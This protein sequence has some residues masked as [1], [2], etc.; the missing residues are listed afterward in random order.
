MPPSIPI[1]RRWRRAGAALLVALAHA[2]SA[3]ASPEAYVRAMVR[4]TEAAIERPLREVERLAFVE[5]L[6]AFHA[7]HPERARASLVILPEA[8]EAMRAPAIAAVRPRMLDL[9]RGE[10][11]RE[12]ADGAWRRSP[13]ANILASYDPWLAVDAEGGHVLT[14]SD[15]AGLLRLAKLRRAPSALPPA[16]PADVVEEASGALIARFRAASPGER[17]VL[18]NLDVL[19][20]GIADL[21]PGADAATRRRLMAH[22]EQGT[23]LAEPL[24]QRL[25]GVTDVEMARARILDRINRLN[26]VLIEYQT[27]QNALDSVAG[28]LGRW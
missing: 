9:I 4:F 11:V 28:T 18:S 26:R 20:T 25:Y 12:G 5:E 19:W 13:F 6:E 8:T 23:A 16:P 21:W 14:A 24:R 2:T 27:M 3:A 1:A 17:A 7:E 15:V 10:R 22:L